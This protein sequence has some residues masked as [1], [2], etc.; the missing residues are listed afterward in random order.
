MAGRGTDKVL[1]GNPDALDISHD[2]WERDHNKVV[3]VGGLHIIGT[4]RH[5]AGESTISSA[6]VRDGRATQE[7]LGSTS[8]WTT[9]SCAALAARGSRPS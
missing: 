4:E 6:G 8:R 1:G 5:E 2:E 9:I 3:E 7:A